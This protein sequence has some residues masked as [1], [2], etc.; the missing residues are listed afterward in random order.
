MRLLEGTRAALMLGA[1]V[2][3]MTFAGGAR[4][5][6]ADEARPA[7]GSTVLQRLV[8]GAGADK[9]A[10]DT[11]QAVTVLDQ[12]DI[13][14]EQA[15]TVGEALDF[16]PGVQSI[17]S[18]R[19]AGQSYNI[20]GI[21]D[22]A[23]SDETK[24]IVNIDGAPKFHEQYRLGSL[25]T[26]PELYKSVEILRG[27]AS[28]T[29]YGSGTY[30]GVINLVTKD[31]EDFLGEGEWLAV[32]LKVGY[33]S[34]PDGWLGSAIAAMRLTESTSLLV[35]GNLRDFGD[36]KNGSGVTVEGSNYD[37]FSGL[38]KLTSR[39]GDADEQELRLSYQ[40]WD[41]DQDNAHFEQTGTT[42]PFPAFP[43]FLG[44]ANP[45]GSIDRE[46]TDETAVLSYS[47]PDSDNPWI[48]LNVNFSWSRTK[49]YQHDWQPGEPVLAGDILFEDSIYGNETWQAK[50]DNTFEIV[51]GNYENF[52]TVG[53]AYSHQDR[54]ANAEIS[55][56]VPFHPE[57][58]EEKIGV[59]AQNEFILNEKLTVIA[60]IR[61]DF[62]DITPD[63]NVPGGMPRSESTFSPKIAAAYRF[64]E[65][66]SVFGSIAGTERA[67]T[68]DELYT[69]YPVPMGCRPGD[70]R[71]FPGGATTSQQ[72]QP[73]E[74]LNYE[75]GFTVSAFDLFT[76]G[77]SFQLKATAFRNNITNLITLNPDH[78]N[79]MP[80]TYYVNLD[81][82][83]IE[84]VE[85]EAAYESDY[86]FGRLAFSNI[87]GEDRLTGAPLD[88][89]PATTVALSLGGYMPQHG[90]KYGW[91]GTFVS[92]AKNGADGPTP[93]Y[94]LHDVFVNWKPEHGA[95]AGMEFIASIENIF[96]KQY[97]NNLYHEDGPG[98]TFKLTVARQFGFTR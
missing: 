20:R 95:L 76:S 50:I 84:G 35:Q 58:T 3:V 66:F 29:L 31:A 37:T 59:F 30:G 70:T 81:R 79:P 80:V 9:I 24:V 75:V 8:V 89:I 7:G 2:G 61:G 71:C 51:G 78:T 54:I 38:V 64:S 40:R 91:R 86:L 28:S 25:F 46:I 63:A 33:D 52:L 72:L 74:S 39:F 16:V 62:V 65:S 13:D 26:D 23:A 98:R 41:N 17:G 44:V 90:V 53:A 67:P 96:D 60:G 43:P 55:G 83:R 87:H 69:T 42:A 19:A 88:T 68:I 48:D 34:N 85:V 32:R 4:A 47:N 15:A 21:G 18:N 93:G 10:I 97:R 14:Q 49:V 45:F 77:D 57:G 6:D 94:V 36:Y 5:Q 22:F 56:L 73:E 1:A 82:A 12:E 27:P 11:P 92:A